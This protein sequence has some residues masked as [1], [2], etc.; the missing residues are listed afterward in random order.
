GHESWWPATGCARCSRRREFR[1]G[2]HCRC[3]GKYNIT[4]VVDSRYPMRRFLIAGVDDV[5]GHLVFWS[6]TEAPN[7]LHL[8]QGGS[9]VIASESI[10]DWTI[11]RDGIAFGGFSL[12]V[13]R[14][15][16]SKEDQMK[17]DKH[18]GIREL[19]LDA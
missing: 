16:L 12:R 18:T 10:E 4:D 9:F 3:G 14:S 11:N 2:W 8:K 15:R 19:N 5:L 1:F 13:I 17:F 6:A 7:A